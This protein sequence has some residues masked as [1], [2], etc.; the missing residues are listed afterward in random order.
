MKS[1]QISRSDFLY[2]FSRRKQ[3]ACRMA[4]VD[5]LVET[6]LGQKRCL[7]TQQWLRGYRP[8][9][10][11]LNFISRKFGRA[12]NLRKQIQNLIEVLDQ[13]GCRN[14]GGERCQA[15]SGAHGGPDSVQ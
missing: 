8:A 5:G 14:T 3:D 11:T 4:A 15:R 13:S 6:F 2:G 12:H 1:S 10:I 7:S 9:F